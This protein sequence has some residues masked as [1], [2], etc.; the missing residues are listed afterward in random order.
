[1]QALFELMPVFVNTMLIISLFICFTV[2]LPVIS[3][4]NKWKVTLKEKLQGRLRISALLPEA[5]VTLLQQGKT[6]PKVQYK[7]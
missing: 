3:G 7:T 4:T 6:I 1:M 2:F 5:D